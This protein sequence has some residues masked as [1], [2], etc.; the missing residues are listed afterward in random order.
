MIFSTFSQYKD[1][2]VSLAKY[3]NS[4]CNVE[5]SA[6]EEA[7]PSAWDLTPLPV[8]KLTEANGKPVAESNPPINLLPKSTAF[9]KYISFLLK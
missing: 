1:S 5:T 2:P 8:F 9:S 3:L 7:P 6:V 4:N